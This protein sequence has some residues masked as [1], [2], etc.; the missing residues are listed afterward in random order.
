LVDKDVCVPSGLLASSDC[1][2]VARETFI[3]GTEPDRRDDQ[4][5]RI[6]I[7]PRTGQPATAET[8]VAALRYRVAWNPPPM[9]RDWARQ[10]GLL[11]ADEAHPVETVPSSVHASTLQVLSPEP[12]ATYL[13]DSRLLAS[14]QKLQL[15]VAYTGGEPV[16]QVTYVLDSVPVAVVETWPWTVWWPLSQG[17]HSLQA[18]ART[19]S[20]NLERSEIVT[21]TVE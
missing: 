14:S 17:R 13:A 20:G 19:L 1:P 5:R 4:Y 12:N 10:N 3:A 7:D 2:Q 18:L 21:F 6:A 16:N 9:F 8:P 11:L 15:A